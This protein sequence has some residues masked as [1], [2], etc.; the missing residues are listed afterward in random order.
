MGTDTY[1]RRPLSIILE[2]LD[3]LLRQGV[4]YVYFIDEIFLPRTDLLEALVGR[5]VKFGIQT[6]IELWDRDLLKLLGAAGCVSIEAGVESLAESGRRLLNRETPASLEN[7][8][9]LLVTAKNFMPF[10]QGNLMD[11]HV[12]TPE[13]VEAWRRRLQDHGVWAN[14]PVPI[15][16]YPGSP[17]YRERWGEPDDLAW[18]RAHENYLQSCPVLSDLQDQQ[19]LSLSR[20]EALSG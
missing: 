18:E 12:D 9:E 13:E 1:R 16:F 2:E 10:V 14:Q 19:P 5:G 7:L 20:L 15:F 11:L 4:E 8:T 6:R 17:G 3:G